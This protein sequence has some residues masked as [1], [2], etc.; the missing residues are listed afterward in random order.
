MYLKADGKNDEKGGYPNKRKG[1]ARE[2]ERLRLEIRASG[3]L[4]GSQSDRR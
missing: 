4:K 3:I 1:G 2:R